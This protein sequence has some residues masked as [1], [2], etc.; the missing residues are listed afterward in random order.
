MRYE[1]PSKKDRYF[2]KFLGQGLRYEISDFV[3]M[4][5]G[6]QGRSYKFT[7]EESI[8]IA[9]VMEQFLAK[10]EAERREGL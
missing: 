7:E 5:H 1:D 6:H 9:G 3:Y 10:R 2:S 8:A 4:I